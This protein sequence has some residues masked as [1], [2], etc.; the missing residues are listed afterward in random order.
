MTGIFIFFGNVSGVQD[1]ELGLGIFLLCTSLA[2]LL[3][4]AALQFFVRKIVRLRHRL[5]DLN[6]EHRDLAGFLARFANGMRG[7]D[8][9]EGVMHATARDVAEKI[10]AESVCIYE[11]SGKEL[12]AIGVSGPY[13]LVHTR[14]QEI[15]QDSHRLFEALKRERIVSGEGFLGEIMRREASELIFDA[16]VDKRFFEYPQCLKMGSVMAVSLTRNDELSLVTVALNCAGQSLQSF[17]KF[18]FERF[19]NLGGRIQMVHQLSQVFSEIT[20]RDRIDQELVFARSLQSSLLPPVFPKWEGFSIAAKTS[21][22]KEVNGDFYDFIQIDDDR[23]L[24]LLGDACG[25]GIPACLLA[26]MTRSFARS[27]ADSFTTLPDFLTE[28]NAKLYRDTEADRFITLGCCLLDRRHSLIEFGRAGHTDLITFV[29]QHLR[30]LSPEGA[31]LGIMPREF[32]A[33]ETICMTMEKGTHAIMFSD[34]LTEACDENGNEFG[35][36]RLAE[37]FFNGCT[38]S[39]TQEKIMDTIV[40]AIS[41]FEKEQTDDRTVVLIS[42]GDDEA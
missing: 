1:E 23:V 21:S 34:G 3:L 25:K 18:Q 33:F 27:L 24:V 8:G 40:T 16:S 2:V 29:H 17:S 37:A 35:V 30:T 7:E 6:D 42:R 32:A 5:T 15:F 10:G 22:A 31:A 41:S 11:V 28:L 39:R 14:N 13:L 19:R 20:R 9:L 38:V 36:K 26:M 12:T 4:I